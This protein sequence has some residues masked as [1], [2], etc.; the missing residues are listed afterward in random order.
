MWASRISDFP[1]GVLVIVVVLLPSAAHAQLVAD[2]D[3]SARQHLTSGID[4]LQN[5]NYGVALR[6]IRPLWQEDPDGYV[7]GLGS[8]AYWLGRCFADAQNA[9]Q[10]QQMWQSGMALLRMKGRFD[11][12]LQDAYVRLILQEERRNLYPSAIDAFLQLFEE[13]GSVVDST[14]KTIVQRRVTQAAPLLPHAKRQQL[15]SRSSR[16]VHDMYRL[17]AEQGPELAAWWRAQDPDPGTP[18]NERILEHLRRVQHAASE[19]ACESCP[20]GYDDRGTVYVRLG[21]PENRNDVFYDYFEIPLG[22]GFDP[23]DHSI[24]F[25]P[26]YGQYAIFPMVDRG[27]AYRTS[28]TEALIPRSF[29][30]GFS[31]SRRGTRKTVATLRTIQWVYRELVR[32]DQYARIYA[33]V[34]EYLNRV[35][36]PRRRPQS[37]AMSYLQQIRQAD[38]ELAS[39]RR[40]RVPRQ[41]SLVHDGLRT[42]RTV[43]RTTRFLEPDG[44]TRTLLSWSHA[45]ET[46]PTPG[47]V[48]AHAV[49]YD[50]TYQTQQRKE[51]TY[52]AVADSTADLGQV[53]A[54]TVNDIR[55]PHHVHLQWDAYPRDSLADGRLVHA[56]RTHTAVARYDTLKALP[57]DPGRLVLSDLLPGR[58]RPSASPKDTAGIGPRGEVFTPYPFSRIRVDQPLSLYFEVYNLTF[59]GDD[60]TDYMITYA[61]ERKMPGQWAFGEGRDEQTATTIESEGTSRQSGEVIELD[62]SEAIG[63]EALRI[64]VRVIDQ[65][66]G[67]TAERSL[68]FDVVE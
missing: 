60:R 7:E 47:V 65:V 45:P 49:H 54:L 1:L 19:Y 55:G 68:R 44:T 56:E 3:R 23:P 12:R 64:T 46:L 31:H 17:R 4:A 8:Y 29:R 15:L 2:G 42:I 43:A 38:Y 13:A 35:S 58:Y 32:N 61:L 51:R 48:V 67:R 28:D 33:E 36:Q 21:P 10:A 27:E 57:T 6:Q 5:E 37:L 14:G 40:K 30:H 24:W 39:Q 59:G 18:H 63:A 34:W 41:R 26:E 62:L 16:G 50:S 52:P 11:P 22:M 9:E 66:S 53:R 25:Y 20:A